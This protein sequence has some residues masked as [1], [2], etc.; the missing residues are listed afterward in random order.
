[1]INHYKTNSKKKKKKKK[2]KNKYNISKND[3]KKLNISYIVLNILIKISS[4]M[5]LINYLLLYKVLSLK[6]VNFFLK[7]KNF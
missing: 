6:K 3:S 1:M 2:K 7:K 4:L 5:L